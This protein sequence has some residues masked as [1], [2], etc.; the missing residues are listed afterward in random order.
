MCECVLLT[1]YSNS[2]PCCNAIIHTGYGNRPIPP[3]ACIAL[4]YE[5]KGDCDGIY[6]LE[7]VY[8]VIYSTLVFIYDVK[9]RSE[10]L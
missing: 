4:H 7:A 9:F 8:F 5:F 10:N 2:S 3:A 1:D 6:V